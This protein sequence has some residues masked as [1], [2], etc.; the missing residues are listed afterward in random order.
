M[1]MSKK[2]SIII[3]CYNVEKYIDRCIRSLVKQTIGIEQ[4]E[5]ICVDDA[6][7]DG[8][9]EKLKR[10]EKRFPASIL[11]ILCEQ[12]GKQG[13]ARNIGFSHANADYIGYVD[14]DDW[15]EDSMFEK[16]Y[17]AALE[18]DT[19]IDNYVEKIRSQLKQLLKEH[20]ALKLN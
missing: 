1:K 8:T 11:L 5:L 4:L 12:N 9:V 18:N 7:T 14:A 19:D 2:I 17:D 13:T 10:W 20:G 15:V 16:L 3:P 6:S